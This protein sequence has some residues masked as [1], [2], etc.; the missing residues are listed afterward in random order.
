MLYK[1]LICS[2]SLLGFAKW[3]IRINWQCA[4]LDVSVDSMETLKLKLISHSLQSSKGHAAA[5]TAVET[6]MRELLLV[7]TVLSYGSDSACHP[8]FDEA[9]RSLDSSRDLHWCSRYDIG[10]GCASL[11]LIQAHFVSGLPF[12]KIFRAGHAYHPG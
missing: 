1:V 6:G 4:L 10:G 9:A 2:N 12:D 8:A 7:R 5:C 11:Y 3:G